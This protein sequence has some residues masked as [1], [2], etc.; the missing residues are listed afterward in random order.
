ML[1]LKMNTIVSPG[2][3]SELLE[4]P[5]RILGTTNNFYIA[6]DL[7]LTPNK[8]WLVDKILLA[9]EISAGA[10]FVSVEFP[11]AFLIRGDDEIGERELNSREKNW[12]LIKGLVEGKTPQDL[13][14]A[15]F[16][17]FV[18]SHAK[19]KDVDRKL[20]YRLLY[21]YWSMGQTKNAFLWDTSRCG[22]RGKPKDRSSGIVPG[23]REK[24]R[25]V[26]VEGGA[27]LLNE[28]HMSAIRS[29]YMRHATGLCGSYQDCF[30]WMLDKYY[31]TIKADG[32]H[33]DIERNTHP[34]IGQMIY[35]GRNYFDD[36]Y[37]LKGRN[38]TKRW[39]KDLRSIVGS[40]SQGLT[41]PCQ[42][43]EIDSTIA[44]VYLVHRINRNW[45][46]GRPV[47][48]VVVDSYTRMI[49]GIHVGLEGPSW[50]GARHALFNAY[51]PKKEFCK[52]YNVEIE[53]DDWPCHHLPIEL[54]ADR[55][56]LL[57]NAGETMAN[58]LGTVI[59]I[60]PPYRAD[61][62]GIV[63]SR[64]R[65]I[66]EK[67]DIKF[68]PGG[69]DARRLERGDRDY[70][71]DAV[72]DI[73]EFTEMM[74]LGV[75]AHN[76][77]L[78]VPHL[79][80]PAMI[81]EDLEPTP[82]NI[83]NWSMDRNLV[84]AKA[85][86]PAELKIALLPSKECRVTRAGIYFEGVMYTCELARR[87]KWLES[88]HNFK[89]KYVR[90]WYDPNS[91]ENCWVRNG[92]EFQSMTLVP[93]QSQNYRGYRMEEVVDILH[94]VRKPSP[95]LKYERNND[96]ANLKARQEDILD[97]AKSKLA[98]VNYP[99]SK[100]EFKRNKREKRKVESQIER[101]LDTADLNQLRVSD[102]AIPSV[103]KE[104]E[105]QPKLVSARGAAFLKLVVTE[106]K[107]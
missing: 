42:R 54:T 47:I 17:K 65:L 40:A 94:A 74:I 37:T 93:G 51:T 96:G 79:L 72:L 29:A 90:V 97:R 67:L 15:D 77:N 50:N 1:D 101:D 83:W 88:S 85:M 53:D 103:E 38:G 14:V 64:F 21:R 81:A 63:E 34:T 30:Y 68:L 78:R 11:L 49:V 12:N 66:N 52:R 9:S 59:N 7:S 60:L 36:L 33:G 98:A 92:A 57:S 55:A 99:V 61:W 69:V 70:E 4:K 20:I 100:T 46:I 45:L 26:D 106:S 2:Q 32:T 44:D 6:I 76:K 82:I 48:Y 89:T 35:N 95:D 5:T 80:T 91:I 18:S 56:E 71:L 104:H 102:S 3:G 86:S 87:E 10:A 73:D 25:G 24:Y 28:R 107:G 43:Y 19:E 23:R 62:K 13:L 41:G 58:T 75:I 22:G 27:V 105:V 31:R 84:D 39:N 8:P 16:G